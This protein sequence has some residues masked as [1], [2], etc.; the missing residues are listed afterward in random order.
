MANNKHA[1]DANDIPTT[2]EPW[3]VVGNGKQA[4][5]FYIRA[6]GA[7]EA[8]HMEDPGGGLVARLLVDGAG[9]W[10]SGGIATALQDEADHG[11]RLIRMVLTMRDPDALFA[12]AIEAG[13][14]VVVPVGEEYGW[15]L[16]RLA[17]PFGH[18]WEIGRPLDT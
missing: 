11:K 12:K 5:D 6:F 10:I 17:D 15:R 1:G 16:G 18:H 14:T 3:L 8:Y 13:A 4:L 9:F 2:I 7:E